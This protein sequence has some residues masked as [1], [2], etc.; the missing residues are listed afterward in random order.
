MIYL[1]STAARKGLICAFASVDFWSTA[2]TLIFILLKKMDSLLVEN[3]LKGEQ[4]ILNNNKK[5]F[6]QAGE[7]LWARLPYN[8]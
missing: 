8:F 5:Y 2:A 1:A 6:L 7:S 3:G 4:S